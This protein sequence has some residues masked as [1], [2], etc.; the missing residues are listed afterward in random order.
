MEDEELKFNSQTLIGKGHEKVSLKTKFLYKN[1]LKG[2]I[3]I[4][5]ILRFMVFY[6]L[7]RERDF[8]CQ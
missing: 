1:E 8:Q 5:F 7:W 4:D 2:R 6:N 3:V